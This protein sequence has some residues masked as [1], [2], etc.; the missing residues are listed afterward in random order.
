MLL[1]V[2]LTGTDFHPRPAAKD[3]IHSISQTHYC[4]PQIPFIF[5]CGNFPWFWLC[6]ND[7]TIIQE[8]MAVWMKQIEGDMWQE[9]EEMWTVGA[10]LPA[11]SG[12]G[13]R[14]GG[15]GAFV[16]SAK[17][18]QPQ[19]NVYPFPRATI[20]DY[21]RLGGL[22]PQTL[23]EVWK[24]K[25]PYRGV[26][27]TG[28]LCRLWGRICPM[29]FPSSQQL[30][31]TPGVPWLVAAPFSSLPPPSHAFFPL[32]VCEL[33]LSWTLYRDTTTMNLGP[34]LTRGSSS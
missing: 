16:S 18:M 2:Q 29:L 10:L 4:S 33:H 8:L 1:K 34:S 11:W 25:V 12:R 14:G 28:S 15:S 23:S 27:R 19:N 7:I 24:L 30:T 32:H 26:G 13:L 9:Q 20:T 17:G 3:Q 5:P 31:A 21:H 6:S 22:K